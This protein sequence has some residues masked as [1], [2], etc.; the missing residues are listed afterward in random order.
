M[1]LREREAPGRVLPILIGAAEAD[2]IDLV[3]RGITPPR[4][5]THD[6]LRIVIEELGASVTSVV[7]SELRDH[8]FFAE[9]HLQIAGGPHIVSARPSDCVALA[10]RIGC[11]LFVSEA[12]MAAAGQVPAEDE[13]TSPELIEEFQA[14][15]E[16]V[17]PD[18]FAS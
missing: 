2:A 7:V 17:S 12:V 14:F 5:L 16:N 3:L 11:P 4:P 6:L 10:V 9:L 1:L 13:E 8:T 15:I 18:D